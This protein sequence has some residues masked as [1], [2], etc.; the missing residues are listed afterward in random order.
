MTACRI[1]NIN[2]AGKGIC[3]PCEINHWKTLYQE[4]LGT[5]TKW[6]SIA[7]DAALDLARENGTSASEILR[8]LEQQYDKTDD[9]YP[10]TNI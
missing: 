1:C 7:F 2:F 6:A 9:T 8:Q 3:P 4:E 10:E 5:S